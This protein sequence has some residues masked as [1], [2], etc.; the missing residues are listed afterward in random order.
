MGFGQP[1]LSD[2][3]K[4]GCTVWV[5]VDGGKLDPKAAEGQFMG[6]DSEQKG[7]RVYW[8]EKHSISVEQNV[9]FVPDEVIIPEATHSEGEQVRQTKPIV[10][11][12]SKT[13]QITQPQDTPAANNNIH[14]PETP[15]RL[16]DGLDPPIP[17]TGQGL[18]ERKP[19]G[20]YKQMHEGKLSAQVAKIDEDDEGTIFRLEIALA[21]GDEDDPCSIGEA[22]AG[23]EADH[24]AKAMKTE[25]TQLE[26]LCTWEIVDPP[27]GA[28]IINSG[29]VFHR[30]RDV[31]GNIA[32]HKAHFIGKGYSQ[33]YGV[34]YYETF[35]PS[36]KMSSQ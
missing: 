20:D 33:V 31:K 16:S 26:C 25:I 35:A 28:N 23:P 32:S 12:A 17:G 8:A 21:L 5:K 18:R 1:N 7:Y 6:Y 19:P 2:L 9:R 30:K 4:W 10:L 13:T 27:P 15:Q 24:W 29:F 14:E 11:S 36:V 22:L 3:R 34:N